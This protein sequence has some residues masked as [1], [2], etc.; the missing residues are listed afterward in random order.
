MTS[1]GGAN[2][3]RHEGSEAPEPEMFRFGARS[4]AQQLLHDVIVSFLPA[5][6]F[7]L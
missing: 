7:V 1:K 6:G 4:C 2:K 5:P 3:R